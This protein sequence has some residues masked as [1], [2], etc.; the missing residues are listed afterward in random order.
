[1]RL[2][3]SE[4]DDG[5]PPARGLPRDYFTDREDVKRFL[6][7]ERQG[8]QRR[9]RLLNERWRRAEAQKEKQPTTSEPSEGEQRKT[10]HQGLQ[11]SFSMRTGRRSLN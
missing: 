1:M 8:W 3:T 4:R 7:E 11:L 5:I 10:R 9:E 2:G 6:R